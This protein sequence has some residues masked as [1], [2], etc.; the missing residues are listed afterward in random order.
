[1]TNRDRP[2]TN[3]DTESLLRELERRHLI[4]QDRI[5]DIR[6]WRGTLHLRI[7]PYTPW[8][9]TLREDPHTPY[10]I[11][12]LVLKTLGEELCLEL[13]Q[14]WPQDTGPTV[15]LDRL[16]RLLDQGG[17][18]TWEREV[19]L[20]ALRIAPERPQDKTPLTAHD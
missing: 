6:A 13:P 9:L 5:I 7:S 8:K 1:M 18:I 2:M 15:A 4:K 14:I 20:D 10:N 3:R 19:L 16:Y 12:T 17:F 11:Q